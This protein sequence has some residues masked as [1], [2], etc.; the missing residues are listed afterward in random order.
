MCVGK[1]VQGW[2]VSTDAGRQILLVSVAKNKSRAL[3][4]WRHL[5]FSLSLRIFNIFSNQD[6]S[7]PAASVVAGVGVTSPPLSGAKKQNGEV[8]PKIKLLLPALLFCHKI[9]DYHGNRPTTTS[10][11]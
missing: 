5:N 6:D 3:S 2:G 9:N 11:H 1:G 8:M 7:Y 4:T 10:V